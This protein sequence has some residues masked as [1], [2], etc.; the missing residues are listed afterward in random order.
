M[1]SHTKLLSRAFV[2]ELDRKPLFTPEFSTVVGDELH[3]LPRGFRI[4]ENKLLI[5]MMAPQR[6]T[7]RV[8]QHL[9]GSTPQSYVPIGLAGNK[10]CLT[11]MVNR[12]TNTSS[13]DSTD[14]R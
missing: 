1:L 6:H 5:H 9:Q 12:R 7:L 3:C 13:A 8:L 2:R 14:H 10:I 4:Y 11:A